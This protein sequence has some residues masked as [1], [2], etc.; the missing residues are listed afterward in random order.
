MTD[1]TT[2]CY[3]L[4]P[5]RIL[6]EGKARKCRS[7]WICAEPMGGFEPNLLIKNSTRLRGAAIVANRSRP[8]LC[9]EGPCAQRSASV[10]AWAPRPG[11]Y[12]FS[13]DSY[14]LGSDSY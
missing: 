12:P 6:P 5:S 10:T 13:E 1:E 3:R 9:G 14:A 8:D 4:P 2:V 11:N 7:F